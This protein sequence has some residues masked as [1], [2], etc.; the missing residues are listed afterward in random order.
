M[1]WNDFN[2]FEREIVDFNTGL[3]R[4]RSGRRGSSDSAPPRREASS[5]GKG[6]EPQKF[7]EHF[8]LREE[9][10]SEFK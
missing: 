7:N 5:R 2:D 10:G 9:K 6:Q 3:W 8:S 1:I 4:R